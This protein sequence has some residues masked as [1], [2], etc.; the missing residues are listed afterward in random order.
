MQKKAFQRSGEVSKHDADVTSQVLSQQRDC[1][2]LLILDFAK[3]LQLRLAEN[4][5]HSPANYSELQRPKEQRGIVS[6]ALTLENCMKQLQKS[7]KREDKGKTEWL[8]LLLLG[9]LQPPWRKTQMQLLGG[10]VF[11]QICPTKLN[12]RLKAE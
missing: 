6:L 2:L 5:A 9:L 10:P 4:P 11:P 12:C 8:M 1:L 3:H 7:P